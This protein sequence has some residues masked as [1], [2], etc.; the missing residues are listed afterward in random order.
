LKLIRGIQTVL[1]VEEN[2]LF[3]FRVYRI[4]V[5]SLAFEANHEVKHLLATWY[6]GTCVELHGDFSLRLRI[7]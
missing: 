5:T 4:I 3:R 6:I 1:E 7:L 2:D